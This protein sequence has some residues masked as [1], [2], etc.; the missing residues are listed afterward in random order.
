MSELEKIDFKLLNAEKE[1]NLPRT[2]ETYLDGILDLIDL[3]QECASAPID[4]RISLH[5]TRLIER[6]FNTLNTTDYLTKYQAITLW[7]AYIFFNENELIDDESAITY[8]HK[9]NNSCDE[10]ELS[11]ADYQSISHEALY[12]PLSLCKPPVNAVL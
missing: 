1:P 8:M 2:V 6:C 7:N 4:N 10:D 5:V 9:L 11:P 12:L 3:F